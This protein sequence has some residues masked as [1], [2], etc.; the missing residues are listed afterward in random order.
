MIKKFFAFIWGHKVFSLIILA[1][2][3]LSGYF[4][5]NKIFPK[6]GTV[7]YVTA[8]VERGV[9]ISSISGT[10][11]VSASNQ[12][13]IQAKT[14]GDVVAV[15]VK[16][17]QEVKAGDL[18]LS[19]NA[20][21][22]LK[23]VRDAQANLDAARISYEKLVKAADPL[24][25]LQYENA[26]TQAEESK[27]SA[28]E[29]LIK[30]YED[31]F[32]NVANAFLDIPSIMAGLDDMW[33]DYDFETNL[34]NIDWYEDRGSGIT[35]DDAAKSANY[36]SEAEDAY[37]AARS[38]YDAVF[39]EYKNTTRYSAD[40]TIEKLIL[41][42]YEMTRLVSDAVKNGKNFLDHIQDVTARSAYYV[43]TPVQMTNH[44]SSLESYTGETN[45]HV[46][47]LLSI[48]QTITNA[49]SSLISAE[50]T[51]AE[52]TIALADLKAGADTLDI[53][54]QKISL[55]QKEN[56]LLDAREKLADYSVRALFDGVVAAFTAKKG[57][58]VSSGAS[59]GTLITRRQIATISFNEVDAA[60]VRAGQKAT[61]SFDAIE[62]LTLTGQVID[63]DAIGTTN[64]GV[65]SFDVTVAFDVQDE[66]I[67]PG[68]TVTVNII[69]S[70]KADILL[71]NSSAIKTLPGGGNYVEVMASG[72]P[73][74]RTV[75]IGE[76]NDT[77]TEITE[78]LNE[79]DTVISQTITGS[80]SSGSA[81]QSSSDSQ[82]QRQNGPPEGMMMRF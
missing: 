25:V 9:L 57:D 2:V 24:T 7:R 65:V 41:D 52:K 59:L 71:V 51:I 44:I 66:R 55:K 18:L 75:T 14:S 37:K 35:Q 13:N 1:V 34:Q 17:G 42:T 69:L 31:G 68:M 38:S 82:N 50:R 64:S 49:E 8:A 62:D 40:E 10:G 72:T 80:A 48:K 30:A 27:S 39:D 5:L 53:Q 19:L 4:G 23:S 36:R 16:A 73:E 32:N 79:G 77:Q 67:K 63:V 61:L 46:S 11:Q 43:S 28:E 12:V 15:N 74:R 3:G 33:Y 21:E 56:S 47:G 58:S 20:R 54:T 29:S 22:T 45:S 26:L 60:K 76:S 70:S 78:G 6:A 81:S